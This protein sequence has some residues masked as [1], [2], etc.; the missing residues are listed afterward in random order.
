M[1]GTRRCLVGAIAAGLIFATAVAAMA[2]SCTLTLKRR[3]AKSASLD[4][5]TYMYWSVRPQ[6]FS[7]SM[8]TAVAGKG[9]TR[10][11]MAGDKSQADAFKRI[12]KKEPKYQSEQ[13]FRGVLKLGSQE[14][15]FALDAVAPPDAK[16]A[17]PD[18]KDKAAKPSTKPAAIAGALSPLGNL[19]G[20]LA[21]VQPAAGPAT[22]VKAFSYNRL[23]FDF[24]RNG[25]LTDDKI[26]EATA[27]SNR[28]VPV[29]SAAMSYSRFEFPRVDVTIDVE[30]SKL[31]YSFYLEGYAYCSSEFGSVSVRADSAICREGDITLDG[32]RHHLV[33]LDF[34]SNG[35]FDDQSK[36]PE[37]IR[38][39]SGQLYRE[40]GDMLL[41]DPKTNPTTFE[42]PY[43]PTLS[44]CRYEVAKMIPI[45]GRW[46][47]LKISPTGDKLTLTRSTVPLGSVKNQNE[48]FTAL[49]YGDKG[50]LKICGTKDKPV[51]IPEGQWKLFSYTITRQSSEP[52]KAVEKKTP[53][54]KTVQNAAPAEKRSLIGVL[55]KQFAEAIIGGSESPA[56]SPPSFVAGPSFVSATATAKYK[57]VTVR[58]GQTV[59]L[60]FGPPYTPTVTT[61]FYG[62]SNL[63][64]KQVYLAMELVGVAG[65]GCTNM[66]VHG[67][68]PGTP[69]FTITDPKGKVVQQ[70]NF[71]YG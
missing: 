29:S 61:M 53:E 32:K 43:D 63:E 49:V 69:G 44:D 36:I 7:Q 30:G 3:E 23:Y 9:S 20:A 19:L 13:P 57:A 8:T 60:P 28:S 71:E 26:V 70:G 41:V 64:A 47:D 38:L 17:K 59:E 22:A 6:F 14:Y 45:D 4:P 52:G 62:S 55:V 10:P 42:S 67:S 31:D 68:R 15:A 39:A 1:S 50:F 33:L 34:N 40:Q 37:N 11:A 46:Y 58:K 54:K 65:E 16:A 24:N 2:Q 18:A 51:P 27:D 5:V 66:A 48:A 21:G 35:R 12:V 56:V 25:D